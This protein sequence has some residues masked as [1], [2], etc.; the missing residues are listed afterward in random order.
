MVYPEAL[1][2][3]QPTGRTTTQVAWGVASIT[4]S[5]LL[6]QVPCGGMGHGG[7][8]ADRS[9]PGHRCLRRAPSVPEE[10]RG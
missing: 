7:G 1:A 8:R 6:V 5:F 2:S 3:F 9:T 10:R 4:L